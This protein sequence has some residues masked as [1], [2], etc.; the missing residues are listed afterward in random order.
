MLDMTGRVA[1]LSLCTLKVLLGGLELEPGTITHGGLAK[2]Y[3]CGA[4]DRE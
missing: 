1:G 3:L 4:T 2:Q